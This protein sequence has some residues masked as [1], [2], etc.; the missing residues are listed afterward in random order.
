MRK[1]FLHVGFGKKQSSKWAPEGVSVRVGGYQEHMRQV[2]RGMGEWR[3]DYSLLLFLFPSALTLLLFVSCLG[4]LFPWSRL[5][6]APPA[7][8]QHSVYVCNVHPGVPPTDLTLMLHFS[9]FT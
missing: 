7:L 6:G 5:L 1:Q 9:I 3:A 2:L 4:R 8:L